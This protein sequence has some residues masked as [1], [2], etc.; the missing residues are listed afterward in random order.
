MET[1]ILNIYHI[2]ILL[3]LI[4]FTASIVYYFNVAD[5]QHPDEKGKIPIMNFK[6]RG[7]IGLV[8]YS[9]PIIRVAAYENFIIISY[10]KKLIR[11]YYN[12]ISLKESSFL[13]IKS[14]KFQHNKTEYPNNIEILD[15]DNFNLF[16][17]LMKKKSVYFS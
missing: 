3:I 8:R 13:L 10:R 12:E 5:T 6:T 2:F 17:E 15:S 16:I 14:L 11:F 4:G 1:S 9:W 7:V